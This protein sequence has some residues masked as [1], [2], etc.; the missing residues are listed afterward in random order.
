M[1]N[2]S[3]EAETDLIGIEYVTAQ[4]NEHGKQNHPGT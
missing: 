1:Q 3:L 2:H 4:K